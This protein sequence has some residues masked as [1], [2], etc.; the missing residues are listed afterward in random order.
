M[1][2]KYDFTLW[3]PGIPAPGGSKTPFLKKD[4]TIAVRDACKRNKPWRERVACFALKEGAPLLSGPLWVVVTFV[5]PRPQGHLG[6]GRNLGKLRPSAPRLCH[7]NQPDATK[8]WR[9]AEDA[10]T[11][12]LWHDDSQICE[13]W[14][15]KH[16]TTGQHPKPGMLLQVRRVAE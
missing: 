4:G 6:T 9:A 16:Y 14:V 11:G 12:I 13:Q 8:L 10:L 2:G 7:T 5:M 3:V 1:N 15:S